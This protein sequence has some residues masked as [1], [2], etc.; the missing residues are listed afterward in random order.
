MNNISE[1]E[2]MLNLQMTLLM[3]KR[4]EI[5]K[6]ASIGDE[7][8]CPYCRASFIKNTANHAHCSKLCKAH[9]HYETDN[10]RHLE[11]R[12]RSR[13]NCKERDAKQNRKPFPR[14]EE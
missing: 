3:V 4:Y 8:I 2:Q 5:N 10:E 7:L 14:N 1:Q 6:S 12:K 11:N 13:K 9:F